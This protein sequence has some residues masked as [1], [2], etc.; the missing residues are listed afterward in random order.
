ML[1][2]MWLACAGDSGFTHHN[3]EIITPDDTAGDPGA[4]EVD[5]TELTWDE[6]AVGGTIVRSFNLKS[7]GEGPIEITAITLAEGADAGFGVPTSGF[8]FPF[9]IKPGK[10]VPVSVVLTRDRAGA[11]T[12]RVE[13]ASSDPGEPTTSVSLVA[14]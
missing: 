9:R 2:A 10:A 11:A 14:Q 12:G 5:P 4:I 6:D 1:F 13:I 3:G 8:E 7:V